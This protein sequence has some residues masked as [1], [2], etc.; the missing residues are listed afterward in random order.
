MVM[1]SKRMMIK[2]EYRNNLSLIGKTPI[3]TVEN[4]LIPED[5]VLKLKLEY[6]NPNF[7]IKDRTAIGLIEKAEEKGL[8]HPGMHIIEST[9]GNL[10]KS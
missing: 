2:L 6:Y 8:L 9:S 10:G 7:S 3:I 1:L 4:N 5:K